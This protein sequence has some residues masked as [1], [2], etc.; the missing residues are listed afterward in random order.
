MTMRP[1]STEPSATKAAKPGVETITQADYDARRRHDQAGPV[2][3]LMPETT[4]AF[5]Q[6]SPNWDGKYW[7]IWLEPGAGTVLGPINVITDAQA[8]SDN[9]K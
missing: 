8:A 9:E 1:D 3:T 2:G 4:A 7:S 5:A 6:C